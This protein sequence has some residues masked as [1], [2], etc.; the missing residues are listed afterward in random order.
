MLQNRVPDQC[1]IGC[2]MM[3]LTSIIAGRI[4]QFP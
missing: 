1:G 2:I 4:Q 3:Q